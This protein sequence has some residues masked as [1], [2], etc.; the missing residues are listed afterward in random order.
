MLHTCLLVSVQALV[1]LF[2]LMM[3]LNRQINVQTCRYVSCLMYFMFMQV[4]LWLFVMLCTTSLERWLITHSHMCYKRCISM[5]AAIMQIS[6]R[7]SRNHMCMCCFWKCLY[8]WAGSLAGLGTMQ[9]SMLNCCMKT[10]K[11]LES[12]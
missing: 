5:L 6:M 7:S 8:R 9:P 11:G 10:L 12:A 1:T 2:D 4:M 3:S